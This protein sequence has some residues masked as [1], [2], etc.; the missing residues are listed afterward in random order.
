MVTCVDDVTLTGLNE[1]EYSLYIV[2]TDIAGNVA[3]SV[4]HS[5]T[6]GQ[7]ITNELAS[8]Q[9]YILLFLKTHNYS[10]CIYI[11]CEVIFPS[12]L[13]AYSVVIVG[14]NYHQCIV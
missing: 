14:T 5:W 3:N 7:L 10:M 6:V 9:G 13:P 11:F 1:G 4:R 2:A 12:L 8:D